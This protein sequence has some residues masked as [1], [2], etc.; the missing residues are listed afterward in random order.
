M[1]VLGGEGVESRRQGTMKIVQ[2]A[3]RGLAQMRF[4]FGERQFNGVEVGAVRRQVADAPSLGPENPGD[5]LDLVGGEVI[6]DERVAPAQL[7]T[8][9]VLK[10][11]GEDLGIDRSFD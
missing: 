6:E 1:A 3:G 2:G 4:E 5:V 11:G 8:E 9:H 10:I 7:W